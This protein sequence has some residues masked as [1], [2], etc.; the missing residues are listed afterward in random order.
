MTLDQNGL[1]WD[2]NGDVCAVSKTDGSINFLPPSSVTSAY[3]TG[4]W[5]SD[6]SSGASISLTGY[7]AYGCENSTAGAYQMFC[8]A[9]SASPALPSCTGVA[10]QVFLLH[11]K[12]T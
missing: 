7:T 11:I 5:V 4:P 6:A 10:L 12:L 2:Q 1:I 3:I 9:A 8:Y